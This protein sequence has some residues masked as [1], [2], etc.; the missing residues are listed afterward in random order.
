MEHLAYFETEVPLFTKILAPGLGLAEEPNQKF[1]KQESFG[2]NRCQIVAKSL[3]E[4]RQTG[5]N[6]PKERMAAIMHN[7]S[8]SGVDLQHPYINA[9]SEDIY[10]SLEL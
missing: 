9:D 7:F 2:Q 1:A 5:N 8:L 4:A 6:S 3:L 10:T